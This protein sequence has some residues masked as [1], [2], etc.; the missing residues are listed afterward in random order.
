MSIDLTAW[1]DGKA[2]VIV[3]HELW[4]PAIGLFRGGNATQS[5][6]FSQTIL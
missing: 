1:R 3:L 6:L 4:Q 5:Q 2:A